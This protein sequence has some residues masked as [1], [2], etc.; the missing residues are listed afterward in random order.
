MSKRAKAWMPLYVSDFLVATLGWDAGAVGHYIRLLL[1]QWDRGALPA[2]TSAWE[3]LT[4]GVS[5][6]LDVLEEKFPICGD[7][8][9]RNVRLEDEREKAQEV[10]MK[11]VNA[12][13]K[14]AEKR[15]G[16]EPIVGNGESSSADSPPPDPRAA[17]TRGANEARVAFDLAP[18]IKKQ[19]WKRFL[20]M[21]ESIVLRQLLDIEVVTNS[22]K[23]Y[24][25]SPSGSGKYARGPHRLLEEEVWE[26]DPASWGTQQTEDATESMT[27][28]DEIMGG[29]Q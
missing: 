27:I 8:L 3:S 6:Y 4:A 25:A 10:Y 18:T 16:G 13:L 19:G 9:R 12:G 20:R 24:Y 22:F 17:L 14:G 1:V 21:W 5:G 28:L 2:D 26:D 11:R 23:D 7:G 15:W 29:E